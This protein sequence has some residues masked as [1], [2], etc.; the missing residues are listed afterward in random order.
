MEAELTWPRFRCRSRTSGCASGC[1]TPSA[2][3]ARRPAGTPS[4]LTTTSRQ[5]TLPLPPTSVSTPWLQ[6]SLFGTRNAHSGTRPWGHPGHPEE[7]AHRQES[8]STTTSPPPRAQPPA[9]GAGWRAGGQTPLSG[10]GRTHCPDS[11]RAGTWGDPGTSQGHFQADPRASPTP[12][13]EAWQGPSTDPWLL[14]TT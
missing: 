13:Q 8:C 9:R 6:G 12:H 4:V 14:T 10:A 11:G 3:S 2:G 1:P 7:V 5:L